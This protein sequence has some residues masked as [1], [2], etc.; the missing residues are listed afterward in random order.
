MEI[1]LEKV[2]FPP[3]EQFKDNYLRLII[4]LDFILILTIL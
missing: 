1:D 3:Q 4:I 2:N